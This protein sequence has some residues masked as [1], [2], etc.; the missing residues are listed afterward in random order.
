MNHTE[1]QRSIETAGLEARYDAHAKKF[2]SHKIVLAWIM[3]SCLEEYRDIDPQ[4]IADRYIE[5]TEV[6]TVGV[7][8][9]DSTELIRGGSAEDATPGEHRI[10]YDILFRAVAPKGNELVDLI[11]NV[12][13]QNHYHPGYP[14]VSRGIYYCSRMLSSQYG[15]EFQNSEYGKLKK[16]YS[17][18]VC[19]N[20]PADYR[21]SISAY[22]VKERLNVGGKPR[23]TSDYDLLSTVM[24]CLGNP[25]EDNYAGILK[26]LG[27]L[28]SGELQ[29]EEKE[30]ILQNEFHVAMNNE[31]KEEAAIMCNLSQGILQTGIDR[32][33][34]KGAMEK[35]RAMAQ[36]LF[37]KGMSIEEIAEL[38]EYNVNQIKLWLADGH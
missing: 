33:I 22:E 1:L 12:E 3:H 7:L 32:G 8:P 24:I 9:S 28:L 21:N 4:V 26:F 11:L 6:G 5:Y 13:A 17:I 27:T 19:T 20:P 18:W 25:R 14:L 31:M 29:P 37:A 15:R 36:K 16:V 10:T 34:E 35:A 2:L 23:A 38:V 30:T